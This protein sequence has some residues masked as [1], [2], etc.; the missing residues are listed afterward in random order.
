MFFYSLHLL[1]SE[2]S[3]VFIHIGK[4]LPDYLETAVI[5]AR[6]F[7]K[8]CPIF[9][10]GN[11]IALKRASEGLVNSQITSVALET[12][13]PLPEHFRFW[14][15]SKLDRHDRDGFWSHASERFFYLS[16]LIGKFGLT[17]VFHLEYD[18]MLYVNLEELLPVFQKHYPGM[19]VTLDNDNRC[20]PGFVY[21]SHHEP[22]RIL[23]CS[24]AKWAQHKKTDMESLALLKKIE[25]PTVIDTLPIAMKKYPKNPQMASLRPD[26]F[27]NHLEE[28]Q[29]IFDAA[30]LGQFLGGID[31]RN[32][33]SLAGFVNESCVFD[34]SRL[35]FIWEIDEE[36]RKIPYARYLDQTYRINNLH[37]HSKQLKKFSS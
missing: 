8:E 31:P 23:C 24:M 9:L 12:L 29:S 36:G 30:A 17:D 6:L 25:P 14:Q 33:P 32:G 37:I 15:N 5:Q 21:I 3:I 11:E 16:E 1:A 13:H 27:S 2:Y 35:E 20:I 4:T 10:I 26:V 22:L 34:P 18:N 19:A 7:N 28:F